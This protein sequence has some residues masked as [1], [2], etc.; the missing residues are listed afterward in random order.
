MFWNPIPS[1]ELMLEGENSSMESHTNSPH[2]E[3]YSPNPETSFKNYTSQYLENPS[4]DIET[5]ISYE[6]SNKEVNS[7]RHIT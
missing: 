2:L 7:F 3:S 5:D 1:I 6:L 4:I